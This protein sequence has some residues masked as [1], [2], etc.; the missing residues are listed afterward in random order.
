MSP[1]TMTLALRRRQVAALAR[2]TFLEA[3]RDKVLYL[4]LGFGLFVFAASRLLAPLALG[5]DRRITLDVGFAALSA[6]GCL[7]AIF[8]GHQLIFRETE[9]KTLY[10][11]FSRP[12]GRGEFVWGKY[13]GLLLTLI[14]AVA[15]MG[16]LFWIVLVASHY[17]VGLAF[18]EAMLLA[19]C[20]M[21]VLAAIAVW[22]AAVASPVLAGLLTL[23]AWL[24]GHG[25]GDMQS[26]MG[27]TVPVT[28]RALVRVFTWFT[29]RLDLY[30]DI[31]PVVHGGLYPTAQILWGVLYAGCYV[32]AAL[33]AASAL[34]ARHENPL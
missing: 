10:F 6:F 16:M 15:L 7:T 24:V 20:E 14:C 1:A 23:A 33:L 25:A 18:L 11:L 31:G 21:A 13:L 5:E 27:A 30:G 28:A 9:R 26:W 29:P 8:V 17:D 12:L 19:A 34:L 32:C 2:N 22:L 4:F 3:A